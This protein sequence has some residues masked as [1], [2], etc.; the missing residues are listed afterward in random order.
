MAGL[1]LRLRDGTASTLL[2]AGDKV[3]IVNRGSQ[4][5]GLAIYTRSSMI[6]STHLGYNLFDTCCE[7]GHLAPNGGMGLRLRDGTA[8]T[9]LVAGDKVPIVN[10]GSQG[11]GLACGTFVTH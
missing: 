11:R 10:R 8:S 9:L 6:I 3:P 2:V 4:G 1:G 7:P 5:R